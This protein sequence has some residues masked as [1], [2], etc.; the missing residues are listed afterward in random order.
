MK[1]S[2]QKKGTETEITTRNIHNSKRKATFA[3]DTGTVEMLSTI[4]ILLE[5]RE[6]KRLHG[7]KNIQLE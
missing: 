7:D 4:S 6:G 5:G 2:L 3:I 1:N